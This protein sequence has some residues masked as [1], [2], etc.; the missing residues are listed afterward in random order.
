MAA[1]TSLASIVGGVSLGTLSVSALTRDSLQRTRDASRA[2]SVVYEDSKAALL[3]AGEIDASIADGTEFPLAGL[4]VLVKELISVSGM[5]ASAASAASFESL[6]PEEGP[7][8]RQLRTL[9]CVF[10]GKT[11]STEFGFAQHNIGRKMPLNPKLEGLVTGGSSAGSAA[12]VAAGLCAFALGTDTG[13]SVRAPAAFCGITGYLPAPAD[14]SSAG[15]FQLSKRFDRIG[16]LTSTAADLDF[17]LS[18]ISD[19]GKNVGV[20]LKGLKVGIPDARFLEDLDPEV[21]QA[22][23]LAVHKLQKSGV[24]FSQFA[25]PDCSIADRYFSDNLP[26][27]LIA[28][29]GGASIKNYSD[30]LDPVTRAKLLR[31]D[32]AD[33]VLVSN[34]E[35]DDFAAETALALAGLDVWIVP[36]APC[37][38]PPVESLDTVENVLAFQSRASRNTRPVNLMGVPAVSIPVGVPEAGD[39]SAGMQIIGVPDAAPRLSAI[40]ALFE[41]VI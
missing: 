28:S 22:F 17:L 21:E 11:R 24:V 13:G 12:A 8:V 31:N 34:E 10:T 30:Q 37:L 25:L 40:T 6:C 41:T 1:R 26:D 18:R 27:E 2:D 3:R 38:P 14:W 32:E 9:G 33:R 4:T 39:I 19:H 15:I 35:L 5:P 23:L 16:L 20:S 7:L 29:L 36:T